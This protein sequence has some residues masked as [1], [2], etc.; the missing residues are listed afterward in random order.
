MCLWTKGG[1]LEVVILDAAAAA[2]AQLER[3][4]PA[5]R[6]TSAGFARALFELFLGEASVTPLA[7]PIWAAGARELLDSENV[8]RDRS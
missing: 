4:A 2:A 6:L 3:I 5:N 8:K 1:E 7:R